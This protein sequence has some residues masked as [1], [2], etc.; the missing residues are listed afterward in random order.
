MLAILANPP[1]DRIS[2]DDDIIKNKNKNK[3]YIKRRY[4]VCCE[5]MI[6][7]ANSNKK[8]LLFVEF[9]IKTENKHQKAL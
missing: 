3:I 1:H 5:Y 4:T 7:K 6:K 8:A 2:N 9:M